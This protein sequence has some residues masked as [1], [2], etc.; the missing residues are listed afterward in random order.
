MEIIGEFCCDEKSLRRNARRRKK[1][2]IEK[3]VK[4]EEASA[5]FTDEWKKVRESK[6]T[7]RIK[8]SKSYKEV[9]EDRVWSTCYDLGFKCLNDED[10]CSINITG[11]PKD[12]TVIAKDEDNIFIVKCLYSEDGKG[13]QVKAEVKEF[14]ENWSDIQKTIK[15]KWGREAGRINLV[16]VV[17]S[18]EKKEPDLDYIKIY[19]YGQ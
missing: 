5:Y 4:H 16:L 17:S 13:L 14:C 19:F 9:F 6:K 8:K 10:D 2:F 15:Q 1:Q 11:K 12:I 3:S 7:T 18:Q